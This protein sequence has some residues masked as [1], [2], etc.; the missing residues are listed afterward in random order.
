MSLHVLQMSINWEYYDQ[1]GKTGGFSKGQF[2]FTS[3]P[4]ILAILVIWI[5]L[6]FKKK[7]YY[8]SA[9]ILFDKGIN[10]YLTVIIN[11]LIVIILACFILLIG[12]WFINVPNGDFR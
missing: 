5:M 7:K 10:K 2:L 9:E 12:Y 1:Y 4:Q 3:L 11:I 6:Y 8:E